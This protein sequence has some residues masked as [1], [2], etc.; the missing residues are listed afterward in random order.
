MDNS[1]I[2][3]ILKIIGIG[4]LKK[5][6]NYNTNELFNLL[7][8]QVSIICEEKNEIILNNKFVKESRDKIIIND[9][10]F[11]LRCL[12]FNNLHCMYNFKMIEKELV[13]KI[14]NILNDEDIL[15][16]N[17]KELENIKNELD[18][19]SDN[20]NI[21]DLNVYQ[22]YIII[23]NGEYEKDKIINFLKED[24]FKK[25]QYIYTYENNKKKLSGEIEFKNN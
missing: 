18:N 10:Q 3:N 4:D 17:S 14:I 2:Y 23:N 21:W 24:L 7:K 13:L 19:K 1:E 11:D 6:E 20:F 16:Y 8:N 12:T 5:Y 25:K 9:Y 15:A 22:L